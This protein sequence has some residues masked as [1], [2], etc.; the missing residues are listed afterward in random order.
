MINTTIV[1]AFL[2]LGDPLG[3]LVLEEQIVTTILTLKIY[4]N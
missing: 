2:I 3:M 1:T 4:V